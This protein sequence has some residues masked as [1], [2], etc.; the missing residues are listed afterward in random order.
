LRHAGPR[1][2]RAERRWPRARRFGLVSISRI[3]CQKPRRATGARL[4]KRARQLGSRGHI[5][6]TSPQ[7]PRV[8]LL[9]TAIIRRRETGG[10][11]GREEA[12][13]RRDRRTLAMVEQGTVKIQK[14]TSEVVHATRSNTR[15]GRKVCEP[16][17]VRGYGSESRKEQMAHTRE[18]RE[19]QEPR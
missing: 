1:P 2:R 8:K 6:R 16:Q 5:D 15:D 3:R 7:S 14:R 11:M 18:E 9:I 19:S 4:T 17:L 10:A 13:A 12:A